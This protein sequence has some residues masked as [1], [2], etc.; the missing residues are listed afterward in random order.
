MSII[1]VPYT[2][3]DSLHRI[4][5]LIYR[6]PQDNPD[7]TDAPYRLSSW[8]LDYPENVALW[9][10][11]TGRLIVYAAIQEPF[12]T[13]DYAIH[14]DARHLN[15]ESQIVGWA[16]GQRQRRT[17][18]LTPPSPPT[19]NATRPASFMK[20]LACAANVCAWVT[21]GYFRPDGAR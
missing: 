6:H 15:L 2:F 20:L 12:L 17:A 5:D 14:A 7:V 1:R 11:E 9:E 16:V 8:S 18:R 4:T 13:L 10:D 19:A 3:S 21:A